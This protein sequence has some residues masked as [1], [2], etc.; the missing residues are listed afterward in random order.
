MPIYFRPFLS[1]PK[2]NFL[3]TWKIRVFQHGA[4]DDFLSEPF[5]FGHPVGGIRQ[6]TKDADFFSA[7]NLISAKKILKKSLEL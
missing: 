3:K 6:M 4:I 5:V 2:K 7:F 1:I